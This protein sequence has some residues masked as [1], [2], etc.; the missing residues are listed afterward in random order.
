[1]VSEDE[2]KSKYIQYIFDNV[3][4]HIDRLQTDSLEKIAKS[5]LI[6]SYSTYEEYE[7]LDV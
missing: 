5:F 3:I 7:K 6:I 1:M 4:N 2:V